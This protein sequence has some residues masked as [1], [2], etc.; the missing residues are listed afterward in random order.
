MK[1]KL[2]NKLLQYE[3]KHKLFD[4]EFKDIKIWEILRTYVYIEIEQ[5][6]NNLQPLFP[7]K[8]INKK[9]KISFKT[10]KNGLSFFSTKNKDYIF[11]NNPRRVK[12]KDG[13]YYCI[14]TDLLIDL[15][16]KDNK[17]ITL[18]DP[19]WALN[20]SSEI[21]H[22]EPVKT[23]DIIYLD[24]IEYLFNIRK[25]IF[26]TINKKQYKQLNILLK[27]IKDDLEKEFNCNLSN[28]FKLAEEKILYL[29]L[30]HKTYLKALKRI[31]PKAILEFYDAFPSKVL[32]NKV[33]KELNIPIIEIQHGIVTEENPI[34]LKY[35]NLKR[36][37][38]CM[39][40]Y[41]LSYGKKLLNKN[42]MPINKENIYYI[43]SLFLEYKKNEYKNNNS[44]KKNILFISQSNLGKYISEYASKLA[45]LLK[46]QPEYQI[47]YKMH[48]Y[49]IGTDYECLNKPNITII[50]NREKDLYYY[51]S[52]SVAQVGIYSTGIYEGL[53]F[54]LKT[55]I[56]N[57]NFGTEEIKAILKNDKNVYYI[58]DISEIINILNNS[59]NIKVNKNKYWS[60]V[61]K[62]NIKKIIYKISKNNHKK[63]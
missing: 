35:S 57:N 17:C 41:V 11:L 16:K 2:F 1:D 46:D 62:K 24:V 13:L 22:F 52:I 36:K 19:F 45:D 53:N 4:I 25:Y 14:Y 33:A 31:N 15:L 5:I 60:E 32:T 6:H 58:D 49:E 38:D 56:I 54:N 27:S 9:R 12:Q 48:P 21:S 7:Q 37:Y 28:I 43:G 40:D 29:I 20:K 8:K 23:E 50:N 39:P 42:H 10:I 47:I 18:E 63:L 44:N 3:T 55:F 26:K 61:D 34:F 59:K 51:Q 30:M